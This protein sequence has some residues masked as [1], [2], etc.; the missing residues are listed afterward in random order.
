MRGLNKGGYKHLE[1]S[2]THKTTFKS[3]STGMVSDTRALYHNACSLK[4][5]ELEGQSLIAPA[6]L[7]RVLYICYCEW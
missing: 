2:K 4:Q 1:Y 6:G 3:S 7:T 5:E